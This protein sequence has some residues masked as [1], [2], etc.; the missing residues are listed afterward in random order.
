MPN[1]NEVTEKPNLSKV[2]LEIAQQHFNRFQDAP[3]F[4]CEKCQ[5][6][7]PHSFRQSDNR[8][9]VTC[10]TFGCGHQKAL[11]LK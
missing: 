3:L 4:W 7:T 9:V 8:D 11:R 10:L 5:K 2:F 1:R 6:S